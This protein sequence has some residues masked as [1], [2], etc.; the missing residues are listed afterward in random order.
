MLR[1]R[2][3][4]ALGILAATLL[5]AQACFARG[6]EVVTVPSEPEVS[7]ESRAYT[8]QD[9]E[10]LPV[11]SILLNSGWQIQ[12]SCVAKATGEQISEA[13]FDGSAWHK[14]DLPATVVGALVTDK[15][16]PD[17]FFGT[18]LKTLP[19]MN[20]SNKSFFAIQD[21]P[22]ASPFLCSW[23][24][25]AEF[26]VPSN[27][28]QKN[29]WLHF[30]GINYRANVWVNGVKIA[31]AKDVA[32]T[33]RAFEF[34]VSKNL[35]P[36][37]TNAVALEIFAPQKDDLGITW[38]DWNPTPADRDMGI[39]KEVFL[40]TSGDVSVRHPFVATKLDA[41]YKT[42]SLTVSADLRNTA[43]RP[44]KGIFLGDIN[45]IHLEQPVELAAGESRKVSFAPEKF[46]QLKLQDPQL[47]WPYQMGVPNLYTAKLSFATEGQTSDSAS[48]KFGIREV[49]SEITDKGYRLF[50]IN[51]RKLL[52][53][54]AAWAPDM[55]LRWSSERLD[56]DLAYV[57]DMGLNTIRLEGRL[58]H[59]EFFD[60]TDK[61][62]ILVMPGWT[63][64]DAWERWKL[65]KGDQRKVAAASLTDQIG[66]LR[67]HP[68]VFVWL[69]GSDGPPPADVEKM[70]LGIEKDL[71]WPNPIISSASEE[72]TTVTGKS[73]V[74][75]TGPYEYVPP[76]YWL[77]DK[78]AGGA[79]GYN[80]ETSPGPAIPP[81]ESLERFIPKDHLWP[82]DEV[83]NYHSGGERFTTVNVFTD[84]LNRRYGPAVSLD[85]YERKAQAMTYD[86][87]RAMFEAYGRNKY[88]S[89]GVI[90]W[91]LNNGWPS[92]IWHLYDYYLVPAGGY[93]GTKK[94]MEPVHVQYSYDDNSVAVVNSTYEALKDMKVSARI[95]NVDASEKASHDV[96][97]DLAADSSTRAFALPKVEGLSKTYFLRL[98]LSD[99]GGKQL[100]DNFYWLSTKADTLDWARRQDTV[101]T[102]QAEFG[103]LTGLNSLPQIK[104]TA[105]ASSENGVVQVSVSNP[106]SAIAFMVRLRVTRGQGGEDVT[107]IFWQ[108]NYFSVLPGEHRTVTAKF[109]P[110]ALEG[111]EAVVVLDGWNV[112]PVV[113][114]PAAN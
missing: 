52:I 7:T 96:T 62:G 69:N 88:T 20:Y 99:A 15:T 5:A 45:E 16:Y 35:H 33:Y 85:D 47:W 95:Y 73:G 65:W 42:A 53:R 71:G 2:Q 108:D 25:R 48:A 56:A 10:K 43:D 59:D 9:L 54:G 114:G 97:L 113:L 1:F 76:V 32:G 107:P 24:F 34:N 79:Y 75:M 12:S 44:V 17:P 90:Q 86:G 70:Y 100:S 49:T 40:T 87:E 82:I 28:P 93:F 8:A 103:D 94:A 22:A 11:P 111:K 41:K 109:D 78:K 110:A 30:L 68:S 50:K 66:R 19:G 64:C 101:Y 58:D 106:D 27:L 14:S 29:S 23:W 98:Q 60:K 4:C 6:Q 72:K 77:A 92:L 36:G 105:S 55:F 74:K 83:W 31:D 3:L 67:N 37:K 13:G 102:P 89:T 26:D 39:W 63:C 80:T 104:L 84:G 57:H 51:G 38:V 91:M 46:P 21:M 112:D 61:L 18:N 81:R